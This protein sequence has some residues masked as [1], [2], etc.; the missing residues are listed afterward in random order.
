MN[1]NKLKTGDLM[2][3][4]GDKNDDLINHVIEEFTHSEYEH[5]AL[6]IK[7]PWWINLKGIYVLQANKDKNIYPDV[8]NGKKNGVTLNKL[9]DFFCDRDLISIRSV[10]N[11]NWN[12]DLKNK[13]KFFF[14]KV[15]GKSYDTNPINWIGIGIG[16]YFH[17]PMFSHFI[18]KKQKN[19]F[20]CSTLVSFL[21]VN[22][23]WCDKDIN[24]SCQTPANLSKLNFINPY[25]LGNIWRL[26]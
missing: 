18:T 26:K 11:I 17:C 10:K 2:L 5:V 14:N 13:F 4:H 16:S 20:L 12:C 25:V 7:D 15:H 19:T 3:C 22:L 8:I 6:I 21:Y 1:L 23:E 9:E 24:W